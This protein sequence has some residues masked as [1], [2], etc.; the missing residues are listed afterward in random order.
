MVMGA[1]KKSFLQTNATTYMYRFKLNLINLTKLLLTALHSL[2]IN[3]LC[4]VILQCEVRQ[5]VT[6]AKI[7]KGN[8]KD[9][10]KIVFILIKNKYVQVFYSCKF[11]YACRVI[12]LTGGIASK[13][14]GITA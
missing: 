11:M 7:Q 5:L 4:Y 14:N 6:D 13:D 12:Y 2:I 1:A 3:M 10:E 8:I 9:G